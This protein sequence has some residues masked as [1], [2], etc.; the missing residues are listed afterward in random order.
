M[1]SGF[2]A[3]PVNTQARS[4][5]LTIQQPPKART[6]T[7]RSSPPWRPIAHAPSTAIIG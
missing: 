2:Q 7:S 3:K 1:P 4:H 6:V 5:S